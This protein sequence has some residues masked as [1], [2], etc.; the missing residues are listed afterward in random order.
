MLFRIAKLLHF[1]QKTLVRH[2]F[3]DCMAEREQ[4][5]SPYTIIYMADEIRIP[6]FYSFKR[7]LSPLFFMERSGSLMKRRLAEMKRRK[8]FFK[9]CFN[10]ARTAFRFTFMNL[11]E[12]RTC[13]FSSLGE[14][15]FLNAVKFPNKILSLQLQ[16][17]VYL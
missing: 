3:F 13:F 14:K 2:R 1:S 8:N 12:N 9:R 10:H 5:N 7:L 15:K 17:H 4:Q 6:A 11:Q 16:K